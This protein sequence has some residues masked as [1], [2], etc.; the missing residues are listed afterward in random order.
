MNARWSVRA[1]GI[2]FSAALAVCVLLS[3]CGAAGTGDDGS[4]VSTEGVWIGDVDPVSEGGSGRLAVIT[5]SGNSIR[6]DQIDATV[7]FHGKRGTFEISDEQ[8]VANW[9]EALIPHTT[10]TEDGESY[11]PLW[12]PMEFARSLE[13]EGYE[14]PDTETVSWRS[15]DANHVLAGPPGDEV[16]FAR[17][18]SL[19]PMELEWFW[20]TGGSLDTRKSLFLWNDGSFEYN[21]GAD[22]SASM[23]GVWSVGGRYLVLQITTKAGY[24]DPAECDFLYVSPYTLVGNGP[25]ATLTLDIWNGTWEEPSCEAADFLYVLF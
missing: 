10:N 11:T 9:A 6:Y 20:V 8:L 1:K 19:T 7:E 3:A 4:S 17:F 15:V 5:L 22:A 12:V 21:D 25:G 14:Y 2:A 23:E 18:E 24:L 13:I 16:A